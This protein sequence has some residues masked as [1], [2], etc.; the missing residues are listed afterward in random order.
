M[1]LTL[2]RK[3]EAI[4]QSGMEIERYTI[5]SYYDLLLIRNYLHLLETRKPQ[6]DVITEMRTNVKR[7]LEILETE[8]KNHRGQN[9]TGE[10]QGPLLLHNGMKTINSRVKFQFEDRVWSCGKCG[11]ACFY[12]SIQSWRILVCQRELH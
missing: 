9:R 12:G 1:L 2:T 7:E 10:Y 11:D 8:L 6:Y 5:D 3:I 4:V